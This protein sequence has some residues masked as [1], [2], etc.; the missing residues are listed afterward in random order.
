MPGAAYIVSTMSSM[1]LCRPA[2]MSTIGVVGT[3]RTSWPYLM[4]GRTATFDL[5]ASFFQTLDHRFDGVGRALL[6]EIVEHFADA[7]MFGHRAVELGL[8]EAQELR[9]PRRGDGRRARLGGGH[10]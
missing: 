2:S 5:S 8:V 9:R 1:N 7:G 6:V 10:G 4:I 3:R